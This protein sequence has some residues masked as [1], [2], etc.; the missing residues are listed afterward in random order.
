MK[1]SLYRVVEDRPVRK[2]VYAVIFVLTLL[3][4]L[5]SGFLA[6]QWRAQQAISEN[7]GLRVVLSETQAAEQELCNRIVD[8]ELSLATQKFAVTDMR[9]QLTNIHGERAELLEELGFF[10]NLMT[11]DDGPRGLRIGDFNLYPGEGPSSYNFVI[12]VTQAAKI[13]RLVSGQASLLVR[14]TL[15][16]N[17]AQFSLTEL[18]TDKEA[19]LDFRFRYFQDLA[20]VL[21]LP[22]NFVPEAVIVTVRTKKGPPVDKAFPWAVEEA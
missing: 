9:E 18:G 5:G 10:R 11:S 19:S 2:G 6:G 12:L 4:V 21:N 7:A 14:G 17:D 3:L 13:R 15:A 20:G 8:A 1:N 16:G 22:E